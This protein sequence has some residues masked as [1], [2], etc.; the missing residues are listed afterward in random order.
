MD[1]IET[2]VNATAEKNYKNVEYFPV[3]LTGTYLIHKMF[4]HNGL[5]GTSVI[6]EGEV[7]EAQSKVAGG[8][9][10]KPGTKYKKVY[11]LSKYPTVAPGQLKSDI[12]NICGLDEETITK[13][14]LVNVMSDIFKNE[15][16][17]MYRL[18]GVLVNFNTKTIDRSAKGKTD[19][20][21]VKFTHIPETSGNSEKEVETRRARVAP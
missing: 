19:L 15:K 1:F 20:T 21:S 10:P 17:S 3:N 12:L 4:E 2:T 7:V 16:S 11:A 18:S 8:F 6:V 14:D 9:T 13:K 5:G